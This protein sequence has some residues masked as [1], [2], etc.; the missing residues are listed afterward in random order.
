MLRNIACGMI[1]RS[2][3]EGR[4]AWTKWRNTRLRAK[5]GVLSLLQRTRLGWGLSVLTTRSERG[6]SAQDAGCTVNPVRVGPAFF[7]ITLIFGSLPRWFNFG[8]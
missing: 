8:L 7:H 2:L 3:G 1:K 5:G 4:Q 6:V